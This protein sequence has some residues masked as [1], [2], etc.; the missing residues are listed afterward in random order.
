[1]IRTAAIILMLVCVSCT[2]TRRGPLDQA[3]TH[4]SDDHV[5]LLGVVVGF[6]ETENGQFRIEL[7]VTRI[8]AGQSTE[9]AEGDLVSLLVQQRHLHLTFPWS[10]GGHRFT[11]AEPQQW[12]LDFALEYNHDLWVQF[13]TR[14]VGEE[15]VVVY[16][17]EFLRDYRGRCS[18][19][20][21][22]GS[23]EETPPIVIGTVDKIVPVEADLSFAA[24][25]RWGSF[26]TEGTIRDTLMYDY[27]LHLVVVRVLSDHRD[28]VAV[29]DRVTFKTFGNTYAGLCGVEVQWDP[30]DDV[31]KVVKVILP[32]D[33]P[34][35]QDEDAMATEW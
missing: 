10:G 16:H 32:D 28:R 12:L 9:V 15:Q 24:V 21:W 30:E 35:S 34:A 31:G 4:V 1:M 26:G 14:L 23:F 29:G 33:F 5:E 19:F 22:Q 3:G 2:T 13:L 17:D 20:D 6:K 8:A 25:D 18:V 27:E 11:A 7:R